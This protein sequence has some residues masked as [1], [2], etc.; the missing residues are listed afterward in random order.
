MTQEFS[1]L[2]SGPIDCR[3]QIIVSH[4]SWLCKGKVLLWG[5]QNDEPCCYYCF[6][7]FFSFFKF[8]FSGEKTFSFPISAHWII[9]QKCSAGISS[10]VRVW[11]FQK[12]SALELQSE[13]LAAPYGTQPVH[14]LSFPAWVVWKENQPCLESD[15]FSCR[16]GAGLNLK[17]DWTPAGSP[18]SFV[19]TSRSSNHP[20]KSLGVLLTPPLVWRDKLPFSIPSSSKYILNFLQSKSKARS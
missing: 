4:P 17:P 6:C 14:A 3:K 16:G 2:G 10:S 20:A 7:F 11:Q 9:H 19:G 18:L 12:H 1:Y 15:R 13:Q 5:N 8:H